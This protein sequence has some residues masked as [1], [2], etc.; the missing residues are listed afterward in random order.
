M[1]TSA[2][3]PSDSSLCKES[4]YNI[5]KLTIGFYVE[6]NIIAP[7]SLLFHVKPLLFIHWNHSLIGTF[8]GLLG[9]FT[10]DICV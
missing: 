8:R 4:P 2:C 6:K 10:V 3:I 7:L 1:I 5:D 9:V